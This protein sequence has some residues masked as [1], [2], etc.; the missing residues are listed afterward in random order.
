MNEQ[1]IKTI[2]LKDVTC[3]ECKRAIGQREGAMFYQFGFR[4]LFPK[5]S[6]IFCPFLNCGHQNIFRVN[7]NK[8]TCNISIN[9]K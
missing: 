7:T 8:N 1:D 9:S 4:T 5:S 3:E 6:A 2:N